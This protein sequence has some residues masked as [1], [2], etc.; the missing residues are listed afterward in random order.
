MPVFIA[1]AKFP[2]VPLLPGVPQLVRS[3]LFPPSPAPQFQLPG[4]RGALWQ[5]TQAAPVW[6]VFDRDNNEVVRPDSVMEFGYR[7][8]SVESNYPVQRG[9]F[10]SYNRVSLPFE[11]SITLI[12][13]GTLAERTAFLEQVDAMDVGPGALSLYTIRTPEKSYTNVNVVHV[14][15]SRRGAQNACFF[16][17]E[18][19]FRQIKEIQAQYSTVL[20]G[21]TDMMNAQAPS[22]LPFINQGLVQPQPLGFS[23]QS[24]LT[25][26]YFDNLPGVH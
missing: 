8:A 22:A 6:G 12:K 19:H 24:L 18:L 25:N 20:A 4:A 23:T 9:Q 3:I 2:N 16:D 26:G 15:L 14:E 13:G 7:H 1:V 21:T 11:N 10:A 5:S 17:V